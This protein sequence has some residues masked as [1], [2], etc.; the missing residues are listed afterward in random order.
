MATWILTASPRR[1][2]D[3]DADL[4]LERMRSTAGA[5]LAR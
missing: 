4:L 5:P 3:G 2:S 1:V